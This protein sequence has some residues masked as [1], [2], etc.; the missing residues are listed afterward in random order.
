MTY[1]EDAIDGAITLGHESFLHA[2]KDGLPLMDLIKNRGT[3][4]D[5]DKL[6]KELIKRIGKGAWK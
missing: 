5:F 6:N 3:R 4:E 1:Q 2:E